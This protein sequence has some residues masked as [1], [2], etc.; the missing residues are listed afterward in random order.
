[1]IPMAVALKTN[2]YLQCLNLNGNKIDDVA[3]K[4]LASVFET[5]HSITYLGLGNN[6]VTHRGPK[7]LCDV[8]GGVTVNEEEMVEIKAKIVEQ[9]KNKAAEEAARAKAGTCFNFDLI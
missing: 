9:E 3:V 5:Q 2:K 6:Q 7:M 8:V 4:Q 1:M